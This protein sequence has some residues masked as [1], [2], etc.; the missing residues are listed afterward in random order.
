MYMYNEY[1]IYVLL[2]WEP[3][4]NPICEQWYN[5]VIMRYHEYLKPISAK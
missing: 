4:A 3:H 2:L 5:H 1:Y